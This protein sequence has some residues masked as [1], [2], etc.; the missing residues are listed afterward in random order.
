MDLR[1]PVAAHRGVEP[2]GRGALEEVGREER[3]VRRHLVV[4]ALRRRTL[5][6]V[7]DAED[8]VRLQER[9]AAEEDDAGVRIVRRALGDRGHRRLERHPLRPMP[10]VAVAAREIA[11]VS[12][13]Q[14]EMHSSSR[15][16]GRTIRS[17]L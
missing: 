14:R 1:R 12:E 5:A 13:M 16:T 9:L 8:E 11:A 4:V 15:D 17:G 2:H 3:A 7:D 10:L 6:R